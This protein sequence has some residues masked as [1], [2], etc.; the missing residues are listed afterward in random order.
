V[1]SEYAALWHPWLCVN[2]EFVKVPRS[3]GLIIVAGETGKFRQRVRAESTCNIEV[4]SCAQTDE[5]A[6]QRTCT[7]SWGTAPSAYLCGRGA[8]KSDWSSS[9]A[10][11]GWGLL[12]ASARWDLLRDSVALLSSSGSV[13]WHNRWEFRCLIFW[14]MSHD[15]VVFLSIIVGLCPP[16]VPFNHRLRDDEPA[17]QPGCL[18]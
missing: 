4:G 3:A 11:V 17:C 2:E 6:K 10:S 8:A 5:S 15:N 14:R 7:Q 13:D 18:S 1:G 12:R 9:D 16:R